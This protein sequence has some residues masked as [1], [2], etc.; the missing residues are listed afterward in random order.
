MA[1]GTPGNPKYSKGDTV[2][3]EFYDLVTGE[4]VRT[5]VEGEIYIVDAY[6]TFF[7]ESEPSYDIMCKNFK[8]EEK[9]L[10]KHVAESRI[11]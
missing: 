10:F 1:K 3:F 9:V 6:G 4:P 2:S 5:T 11:L 7:D 8:D